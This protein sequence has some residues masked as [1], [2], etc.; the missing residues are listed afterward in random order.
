MKLG[1]NVR[2][3]ISDRI[4]TAMELL[5]N[6]SPINWRLSSI[7]YKIETKSMTCGGI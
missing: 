2:T 6:F 7:L 1:L 4:K 5:Y 3:N